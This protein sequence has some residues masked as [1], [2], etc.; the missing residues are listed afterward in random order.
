ME[1]INEY[2][3]DTQYGQ[4]CIIDLDEYMQK[5]RKH[6]LSDPDIDTFVPIPIY[7]QPMSME[8]I[9]AATTKIN[10]IICCAAISGMCII[11]YAG[12]LIYMFHTA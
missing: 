3:D 12:T 5:S 1:P 9:N 10:R 6:K 7:K 11:V 8:A 2:Y 4:F